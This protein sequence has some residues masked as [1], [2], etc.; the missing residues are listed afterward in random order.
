[1]KANPNIDELLCSFIDG[2]LPLR[3]QTEVR[4]LAARD[5]DVGR[6]LRQLQNSK[7]LVN[8][9]PRAEAPGE[10]LEQI[11]VS[12]ERRTLLEEAPASRRVSA[13]AWHLMLRKSVATA[14][15]IALLAVL[16]VV[17]Y[18]IV[19]PVPETGGPMA[20]LPGN[21]RVAPAPSGT[22]LVAA[23]A[24]FAGRLELRTGAFAQADAFIR[25]AVDDHGMAGSVE[26]DTG[27]STRIYRLAG[28]RE[29]VKR[30][31]TALG[32]IWENFD[33]TTLHVEN[34]RVYAEAVTIEAVTPEQAV[35]IVTQES[36]E[37]SLETAR[38]YAVC[39]RIAREMPGN[40]ILALVNDSAGSAMPLID[41]RKPRL[42]EP[43]KP[44]EKKLAPSDGNAQAS[45]TII[46]RSLK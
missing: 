14:A 35:D 46:L 39:N 4:R 11:R 10:M 25:A 6:R 1:M 9:M 32:S 30:L 21:E 41:I 16:G 17:V 22:N 7:T 45:L 42:T 28:S 5:P 26:S 13:G 31:V 20:S 15:M 19:A 44:T 29:S 24:G 34:P 2:E 23:D 33:A 3:Q 38:N 43:D 40:E 36:T 37:A 12:L 18:H 8:A 27:G